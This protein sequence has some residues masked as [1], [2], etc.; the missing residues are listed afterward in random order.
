MPESI[1]RSGTVPIQS[2]EE[3]P[4]CCFLQMHMRHS[5]A[6]P[7][8]LRKRPSQVTQSNKVHGED[9]LIYSNRIER[10]FFSIGGHADAARQRISGAAGACFYVIGFTQVVFDSLTSDSLVA[11]AGFC[12]LQCRAWGAK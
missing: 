10:L 6:I 5:G 9:P 7:F 3:F 4:T 2:R 8:R 1:R 12:F 11:H